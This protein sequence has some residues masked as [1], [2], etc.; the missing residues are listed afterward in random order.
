[1]AALKPKDRA[2]ETQLFRAAVKGL[3]DLR[4]Y[5]AEVRM[6]GPQHTVQKGLSL[7]AFVKGVTR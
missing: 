3:E 4:D 1:M 5:Y 7:L 6:G 2:K